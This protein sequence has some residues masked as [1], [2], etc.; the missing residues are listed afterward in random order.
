M[1][2]QI[3]IERKAYYDSLEA[4]QKSGLDI[5]ARIEWLLGCLD[6]AFD[7]AEIIL[8]SVLMKA[9]FWERYA[10][11]PLQDRQRLVLHR[12]LGGFEGKLTSSKYAKLAKCSQDTAS[13]DIDDLIARRGRKVV[14]P[15]H[16]TPV[17]RRARLPD[18]RS[19]RSFR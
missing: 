2:A 5:T 17:E 9:R 8:A 1:P 3:R 13:R 6:R 14:S 7:G 12:L 4:T 18:R 15:S 10:G 16:T 19:G 11:V